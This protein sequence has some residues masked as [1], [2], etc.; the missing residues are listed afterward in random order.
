M[1]A[2]S[3]HYITTDSPTAGSNPNKGPVTSIAAHYRVLFLSEHKKN[4]EAIAMTTKVKFIQRYDVRLVRDGR[5]SIMEAPVIIR[6][7]SDALPVLEAELS[8]LAYERF[9]ALALNTKNHVNAVLP[10]SSG[11]LNASIVGSRE[12]FLRAILSNC[13]SLIIAHNHPSGDP[14]PSSEDIQLTKR[15]VEAATILDIPILD[16]ILLGYGRYYSF[17]E[18]GLI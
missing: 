9:I 4:K 3:I 18:H 17:K 11:S 15:L 10:V 16:H 1:F 5:I 12:L 8:E 2:L 14:T 7:P 6:T 13:A